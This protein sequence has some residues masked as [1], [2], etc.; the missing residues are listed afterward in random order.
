M[1][2]AG[3][4]SREE[5]LAEAIAVLTAA[6][7]L[8]HPALQQ[9]AAGDWQPD[10]NRTEASDWAEFVTQA[11][12]GAAANIGGVEAALA[13]R[14]G[15]WEA[16]SIRSLLLATVGHDEAHLFEHRTEP[17]RV[18]VPVDQLLADQGMDEVYDELHAGL[19]VREVEALG[20]TEADEPYVWLYERSDSG[21]FV[22]TDPQA[23]SWSIEAWR[24]DRQAEGYGPEQVAQLERTVLESPLTRSVYIAR[25]PQARTKLRQIDAQQLAITETFRR[26]HEALEEQRREERISYAE[27]LTETVRTRAGRACP[28]VE[29]QVEVVADPIG[30]PSTLTDEPSG[31][32]ARLLAHAREFVRWPGSG[33]E[34]PSRPGR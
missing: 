27:A 5:L 14:P 1:A 17:L 32:E 2:E 8:Q 21:E 19:N 15:S 11:L 23:P 7:R 25:S 12:A 9:T 31:P 6:A 33:H 20:A 16:D 3:P 30:D 24:A 4:R 26:R 13:G 28:G 18:V 10:P 29:V 34:P 22:S